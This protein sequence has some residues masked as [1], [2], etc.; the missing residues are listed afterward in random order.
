MDDDQTQK[1]IEATH[2]RPMYGDVLNEYLLNNT[3]AI[4]TGIQ[5]KVG[6]AILG[7]IGGLVNV[8]GSIVSGNVS[9]AIQ[10]AVGI[11]QSI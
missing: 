5:N 2:Q 9:G 4:N 1:F 10:G 6:S 7:G 8:G 11:G 3:N